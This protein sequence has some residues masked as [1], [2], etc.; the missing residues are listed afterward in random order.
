MPSNVLWH[1]GDRIAP[2]SSKKAVSF[3]SVRKVRRVAVNDDSRDKDA[4]QRRG[5]SVSC[6]QIRE[7]GENGCAS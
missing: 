4:A 5:Y 6:P 2:S 3:S 1:S 7:R